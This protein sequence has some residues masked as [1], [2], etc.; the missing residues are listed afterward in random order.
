MAKQKESFQ[1][2]VQQI[3][4]LMIHSLYSNKEIFLRELVSNASDALDKLRFNSLTEK[5]NINKDDLHIRLIP[6]AKTNTLVIQDNGI[7]MS[8]DEVKDNIGTIARSGT[9][10]FLEQ[11]KKDNKEND[12]IGQFGVGF[13]SSFMVADK[14]TIHTQKIGEDVGVLWESEGKGEYTIDKVARPNGNGTTIT[15]HLKTSEKDS[16]SSFVNYTTEWTLKSL[17]KKYSDFISYPIK[18]NT[19]QKEPKKDKD[20]KVIENEYD[21]VVTDETLNSQKALWLKD[22]KDIKPEEY[23]EF[24]NHVTKDWNQPLDHIHYKAEGV[25]E[26]SALLY[27]PE[28]KPFN[29]FTK[30]YEVGLQL[31]IKRVFI[32]DGCSDLIPAHLRFVKGV[33]DSS[34]LSLNVSRE[35]LQQDRQVLNIKNALSTKIMKHLANMLKK[36]RAN[37]ETFWTEFGSTLKEGLANDFENKEKLEKLLLF[38]TSKSEGKWV[39]LSEYVEAMPEDQK[40]IYFMT[41][42][43]DAA[44]LAS[45]YLEK[46]NN[47]N[48]P[49]LLLS[50]PV[51]EWVVNSLKEFDKKKVQ[52]ITSTDLDLGDAESSKKDL[53]KAEEKYKVIKEQITKALGDKVKDVRFS[54]RLVDS[55]VCLVSEGADPS[56]NMQKIMN[57]LGQDMPATKRVFELNPNHPVIEKMQGLAEDKIS[58]WSEILF[59]QALLAEGS[60]IENPSKYAK[61][62]AD[63]MVDASRA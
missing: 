1:A 3:L 13:Y 58:N 45:P 22:P 24:Y 57:S 59:N 5:L 17:V 19:I 15:L 41:G 56:A 11:L 4:D 55:P 31:Y 33:V 2:E 8:F 25:N 47:K 10:K 60:K 48:Y 23:K 18:M 62:I 16:E 29:Y 36:D 28:K 44:I 46:L 49:V 27:I 53:E 26:F 7:G 42:E 51:D 43:S 37:Y 34:D 38:R 63:L 61:Q 40:N 39:S 6:D 21:E 50:D 14:V 35:I 12:L 52:S 20:G 54:N 30:D 9:K 32:M